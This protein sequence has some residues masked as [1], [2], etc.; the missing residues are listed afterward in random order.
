[1]LVAERLAVERLVIRIDRQLQILAKLPERVDVCEEVFA[2]AAKATTEI[3]VSRRNSGQKIG[4]TIVIR[5]G[6]EFTQRN[7]VEIVVGLIVVAR[8][9]LY[10]RSIVPPLHDLRLG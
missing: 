5:V 1:I 4:R 2:R 8:P 10:E 3:D 9:G 6:T 7:D